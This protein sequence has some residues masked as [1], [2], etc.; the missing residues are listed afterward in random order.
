MRNFVYHR[1]STVAP[2]SSA[3][4]GDM[5]PFKRPLLFYAFLRLKCQEADLPNERN[6]L[7]RDAGV[8]AF[9]V[10]SSTSMMHV[11][12]LLYLD[13]RRNVGGRPTRFTAKALLVQQVLHSLQRW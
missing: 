1:A 8:M 7:A 13:S 4:V 10:V 2:D 9:R 6:T 11:F 3:E 12:E 5:G